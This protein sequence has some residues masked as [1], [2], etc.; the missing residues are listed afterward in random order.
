MTHISHTQRLPQTGGSLTVLN[1]HARGLLL[2]YSV[3]RCVLP[4]D[5]ATSALPIAY[6]ERKVHHVPRGIF[7]PQ[8]LS[9]NFR[10]DPT[11][12]VP[13]ISLLLGCW[14]NKVCC[15]QPLGNTTQSAGGASR[16]GGVLPGASGTASCVPSPGGL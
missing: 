9:M 16:S 12:E 13:S 1:P 2:V 8:L 15:G 3:H 4:A 10:E 11:G 7:N 6:S 5:A 14:V